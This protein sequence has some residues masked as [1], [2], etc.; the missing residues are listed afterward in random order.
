[1][2]L[3]VLMLFSPAAGAEER[4]GA[5]FAASRPSGGEPEKVLTD[6][7]GDPLPAGA[8]ARMGSLRLRHASGG[9]A[10]V[11]F[12]PDGNTLASVGRDKDLRLW[13]VATGRCMDARAHGSNV[14]ALAF[15]AD[16]KILATGTFNGAVCLWPLRE[17]RIQQGEPLRASIE[18]ARVCDLAMSPDGN[19]LAIATLDAVCLWEVPAGREIRRFVGPPRATKCVAFLPDGKRL[20]SAGDDK[21]IRFWD[22]REDR[23]VRQGVNVGDR[24]RGIAVSRDGRTL[25]TAGEGGTVRLWDVETGK[26]AGRCEGHEG[27]VY[28]VAFSRDGRRLVSG[29][30]DGTVRVWELPTA[31]QVHKF[32][33]GPGVVQ[34][35]AFSPSGKLLAS[36]GGGVRLWNLD[37]GKEAFDLPGHHGWINAVAYSPDGKVLATGGR[38]E[39]VRFWDAGSGRP[40]PLFKAQVGEV[41][42]LRFSP[43]GKAL[44]AVVRGTAEGGVE[45]S[46]AVLVWEVQTGRE[47][48]KRREERRWTDAMAFCPA[49]KALACSGTV[50]EPG[51]GP[52]H[53]V[54]ALD[55]STG[56]ELWTVSSEAGASCLAFSGDGKVLVCGGQDGKVRLLNAA[57]G[58]EL[59]K[60]EQGEAVTS[61]AVSSDGTTLATGGEYKTVCLWDMATG[62]SVIR[63][64]EPG[65]RVCDLAFALG[66]AFLLS[67]SGEGSIRLWEVA[68]GKEAFRLDR[69]EATG[70]PFATAPDSRAVACAMPDATVLVW[71]LLPG[72]PSSSR[73]TDLGA[74]E[75]EKLWERLAGEDAPK[76]YE[77]IWALAAAGGKTAAMLK[78]RLKPVRGDDA[79]ARRIKKLIADLDDARYAVR[80]AASKQLGEL[81]DLSAPALRDALARTTSEEVAARIREILRALP[82]PKVDTPEGRRS[83]RAIQVLELI[84]TDQA[85][86]VLKAL[87]GGA[88]LARL[89]RDAKGALRRLEASGKR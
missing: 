28:S 67:G 72:G 27:R 23:E 42:A 83:V 53:T 15:S 78:E 9:V 47:L 88:E 58:G 56:A 57:T 33:A 70:S 62:R 86:E 3:P 84:G 64:E 44:G 20:V 34:S 81:G 63:L 11:A 74:Q 35:V 1:M 25:A 31:K 68:T 13:D 71:G 60:L 82:T 7:Y 12:S 59:Q 19:T 32:A 87:A 50:M 10:C 6:I 16:G 14:T 5:E 49:G 22:V 43:D 48:M 73:K 52:T 80:E 51:K 75:M 85:R 37:S 41:Q 4:S 45:K 2:L 77:A 17:G 30:N 39:T 76:A 8:M 89:T 79:Q 24:V 29:G 18:G 54:S 26:E 46:S 55:A 36:A 69:A 40:L 21:L 66:D 38:D 61:V 65:G